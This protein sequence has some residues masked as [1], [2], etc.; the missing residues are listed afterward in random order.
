MP[1]GPGPLLPF[2]IIRDRFDWSFVI[3]ALEY[4]TASKYGK[5]LVLAHGTADEVARLKDIIQT[6]RPVEGALHA[7]ERAQHATAGAR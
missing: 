1:R 7:V 2:Q 5:F 6:T 4:E 3:R